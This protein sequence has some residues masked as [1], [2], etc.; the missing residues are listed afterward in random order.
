MKSMKLI[1]TF[2]AFLTIFPAH[3]VMSDPNG[4]YTE[5]TLTDAECLQ[6]SGEGYMQLYRDMER[7]WGT[8][9]M[10][11][12]IE[13]TGREMNSRFPNRDRLQVE[14]IAAK[15]GGDISGH[16][17]HENGLDVDIQFYKL[18]GKEHVSRWSG[19]HREFA[20]SMVNQDGSIS[21]NFDVERNWELM[22]SLFRNGRVARIFIDDKLKQALCRYASSKNELMAN[23]NVLRNLSHEENHADHLH[24]RLQCPSGQRGC[25]GQVPRTSGATGCR[26]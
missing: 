9:E 18:D 25:R 10:I 23:A 26:L 24:V 17:S 1:L 13:A 15:H 19:D 12:M 20:P 16:A 3:A 21:S 2:F 4:S 22:K 7:I 6:E 5:G 11:G 14:D 8:S